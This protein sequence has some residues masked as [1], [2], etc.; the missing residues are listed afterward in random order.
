MI[1]M[2]PVDW[3]EQIA[4][5]T[6]TYDPAEWHSERRRDGSLSRAEVEE[7]GGAPGHRA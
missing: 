5:V 2:S 1:L 3:D 6:T 7:P 4:P